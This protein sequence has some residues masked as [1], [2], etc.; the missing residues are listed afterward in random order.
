ML[1]LMAGL[2]AGY[3]AFWLSR[4]VP[5]FRMQESGFPSWPG[6]WE[7]RDS[8]GQAFFGSSVELSHLYEASRPDF[9]EVVDR[10]GLAMREIHHRKDVL[11]G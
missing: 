3:F 10:A 9:Q 7:A 8:S 5:V 11:L 6:E 1:V 2:I 4:D